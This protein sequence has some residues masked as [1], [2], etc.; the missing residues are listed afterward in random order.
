MNFSYQ[1][2]REVIAPLALLIVDT[3]MAATASLSSYPKM[4][5]D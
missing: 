4:T 2:S 3:L 5:G 1:A